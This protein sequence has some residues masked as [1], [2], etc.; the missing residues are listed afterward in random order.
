[1]IPLQSWE[2]AK[3]DGSVN[4]GKNSNHEPNEACELLFIPYTY[5]QDNEKILPLMVRFFM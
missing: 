3:V 1:V 4:F 5:H 2:N